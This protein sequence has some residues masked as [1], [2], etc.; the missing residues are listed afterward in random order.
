MPDPTPS[1]AEPRE[2]ALASLEPIRAWAERERDAAHARMRR[3]MDIEQRRPY[4]ARQQAFAEVVQFIDATRTRAAERLSPPAQVPCDCPEERL[5]QRIVHGSLGSET[6]CARCGC[7]F[8]PPV[9]PPPSSPEPRPATALEQAIRLALEATNGWACYAQ[10]QIEH[11]EISRLHREIAALR[12]A[13]SAPP[14][15]PAR[16]GEE[17]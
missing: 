11:D 16:E 1:P 10:R 7:A 8:G 2:Q 13:R 17:T 6:T 4:F 12:A 3:W 15:S 5:S 9:D 14:A